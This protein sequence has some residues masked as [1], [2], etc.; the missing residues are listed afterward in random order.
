MKI[1]LKKN[2][3]IFA[4]LACLLIL[5]S[6]FDLQISKKIADL[7]EGQYISSN[8]FGRFFETIGST[9]VY[10]VS[11]FALA[12]IFHNI[13]RRERTVSKIIIKDLIVVVSVGLLTYMA[14]QVYGYI[15]DHFAFKHKLG[16]ITD[17]I[18]YL[19]MGGILTFAF[20][21]LTRK[22]SSE[23]LNNAL[24]WAFIIILTALF[25]QIITQ[26]VKSFWGRARFR[27]MNAIGDFSLYSDWFKFVPKRKPD[28][29]MLI[30]G[31]A[32]DGFKSFPS[33]HASSSAILIALTALPQIIPALN[34]KKYKIILNV[35]VFTFI[36]LA[37]FARIL[38]GAHFLSDVSLGAIITFA[39]YLVA[40]LIINKILSKHQ[41]K[42]LKAGKL[43]YRLQ[44]ESIG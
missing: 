7:K 1:N 35:S 22:L 32:S 11:A 16:A 8:L 13:N 27:T 44:E 31:V 34:N 3:I 38:V 23:F 18:A 33:G 42:P 2:V 39:C 12:V 36:A 43:N 5:A 29:M 14:K 15:A 9:P 26:G 20:I 30:L 6:F 37:M 10:L 25:S 21:W 4:V 17:W 41:I 19:L 40:T 24:A 28:D